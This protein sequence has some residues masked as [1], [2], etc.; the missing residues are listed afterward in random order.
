MEKQQEGGRPEKGQVGRSKE[1][2]KKAEA[3][4]KKDNKGKTKKA[5]E[6]VKIGT[7]KG[8]AETNENRKERIAWP[9]ANSPEWE[10]LDE[11]LTEM[12]K[13]QCISAE[14]C[15]VVHPALI[16]TFSLERFGEKGA[17]KKEPQ[18]K[19]PS[20]RQAKCKRLRQEINLLKKAY[21]KQERRKRKA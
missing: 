19:G 6:E 5:K 14:N 20:K 11:D 12:L 15:S 3:K 21:R 18:T 10:R 4:M 9:K 16:Y 17:K 13:V 2:G 1:K 7:Q 8:K